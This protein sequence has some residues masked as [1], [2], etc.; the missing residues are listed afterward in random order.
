MAAKKKDFTKIDTTSAAGRAVTETVTTATSRKGQQ[1]V[2]SPEE[3]QERAE[4]LTTQGRLGCKAV[5]IN[6]AMTPANYLF[7]RTC[8]RRAGM[9]M[10]KLVNQILAM[11]REQHP[12]VNVTDE[13]MAFREKMGLS[14]EE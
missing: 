4:N 6:L 2:A 8:A 5:R 11:Y 13:A 10:T 12:E 9:T 14:S 1:A 7:V 3:A